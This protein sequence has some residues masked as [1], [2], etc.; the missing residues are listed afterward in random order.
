MEEKILSYKEA[1]TR[2]KEI[3]GLIESNQLDIDEL[4]GVLKEAS[5]LLKLCKEKLFF[6]NEETKK[7]LGDIQ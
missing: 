5:S 4:C 1:F 3:Q 7:I 2:L 6:V